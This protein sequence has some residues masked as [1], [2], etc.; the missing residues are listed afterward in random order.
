[1]RYPGLDTIQICGLQN[2]GK[3]TQYFESDAYHLEVRNDR[4][5]RGEQPAVKP[6]K[7]AIVV[8]PLADQAQ[9]SFYRAFVGTYEEKDLLSQPPWGEDFGLGDLPPGQYKISFVQYGFQQY[10][11]QVLP[12]QLTLVTF[13]LGTSQP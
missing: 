7:G 11:V 6:P 12:G 13:Q 1:M 2:S 9:A 5:G 3:E 10:Q 8:E 4:R